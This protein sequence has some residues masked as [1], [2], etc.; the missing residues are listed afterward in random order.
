MHVPKDSTRPLQNGGLSDLKQPQKI[1]IGG[2]R[3]GD[4]QNM[5]KRGSESD[6]LPSLVHTWNH[7]RS[8][9]M[10]ELHK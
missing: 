8:S 6:I 1:S 7:S 3:Y 5:T 2:K 4:N 10:N 9:I